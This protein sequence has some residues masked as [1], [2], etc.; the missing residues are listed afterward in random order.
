MPVTMGWRHPALVLILA[1]LALGG[2]AS[3]AGSKGDTPGA[4]TQQTAGNETGDPLEGVNRKVFAFNETVDTYAL[5]PVARGWQAVTPAV[6]RRSVS[7]FFT[8]LGQPGQ[9]LNDLLQGKPGA[10]TVDTHRFLWNSTIGVAGLFDVASKMGLES[11]PEDFG[12]TL[13]VW[14]VDSGPYLMLPLLG[15]S[16]TRDVTRYPVGWYTDVLAYVSIDTPTR[17]GLTALNVINQ[18]AQLGRAL[19][20][21]DEAALDPYAFTRSSYQQQRRNQL[22]DGNPPAADDDPYGD[23]FDGQGREGPP[24]PPADDAG[25]PPPE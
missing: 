7:N 21:R 22:Y 17:I 9:I 11:N 18:R 3:T 19:S 1:G 20:I 10:A 6:V 8:N 15:P 5:G 23:F 16:S 4:A 25:P 14:G 13:G 12:Q 24:G 2:C